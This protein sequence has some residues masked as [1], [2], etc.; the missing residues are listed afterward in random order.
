MSFLSCVISGYQKAMARIQAQV[1]V[2]NR[3][4]RRNKGIVS[5]V[6]KGL[7]ALNCIY[8]WPLLW[9]SLCEKLQRSHAG[10]IF[11][12]PNIFTVIVHAGHSFIA[13]G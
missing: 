1:I 10:S 9:S 5:L 4:S 6:I 12:L 2:Q 8:P 11:P 13:P 3:S 7:L